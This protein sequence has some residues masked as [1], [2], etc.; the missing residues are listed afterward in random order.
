MFGRGLRVRVGHAQ[1]PAQFSL[2]NGNAPMVLLSTKA[3]EAKVADAIRYASS[4]Q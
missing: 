1:L 3:S 2:I 4:A